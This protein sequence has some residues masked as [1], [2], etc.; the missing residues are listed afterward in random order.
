MVHFTIDWYPGLKDPGTMKDGSGDPGK[1]FTTAMTGIQD[2]GSG[3]PMNC[4][5]IALT[6]VIRCNETERIRCNFL[7]KPVDYCLSL[8]IIWNVL[9]ITF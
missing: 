3:D 7:R 8:E 6:D 1:C 5:T 9:Q 2:P 4:F